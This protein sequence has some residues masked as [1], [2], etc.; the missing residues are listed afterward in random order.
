MQDDLCLEVFLHERTSKRLLEGLSEVQ[1]EAENAG[2]VHLL[3]T[4]PHSNAAGWKVIF[5][6]HFSANLK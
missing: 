3:R 2:N 1:G 5:L 4:K 6:V